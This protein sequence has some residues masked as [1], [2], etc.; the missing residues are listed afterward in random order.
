MLQ[1]NAMS[2]GQAKTRAF[3][4][5][6]TNKW[7]EEAFADIGGNAGAVIGNVDK[8]LTLLSFESHRRH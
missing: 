7:L 1:C 2:E 4:L 3:L 5:A 8:D 6:F